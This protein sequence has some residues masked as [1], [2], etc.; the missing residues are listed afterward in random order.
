MGAL[1]PACCK[2]CLRWTVHVEVMNH[3]IALTHSEIAL[4]FRAKALTRP[5][6][7]IAFEQSIDP[8][9]PLTQW[10]SSTGL[11]H[12]LS[13]RISNLRFEPKVDHCF[14]RANCLV[15]GCKIVAA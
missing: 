14:H 9:V 11:K 7:N 4:Q 2:R 10:L 12:F 3:S 5:H 15:E 6:L 1:T 8:L 13:K